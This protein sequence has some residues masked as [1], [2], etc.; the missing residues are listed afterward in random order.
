MF[1]TFLYQRQK[2]ILVQ[3]WGMSNQ[4]LRDPSEMQASLREFKITL[5]KGGCLVVTGKFLLCLLFLA[6]SLDLS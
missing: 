2:R 1:V 3:E 4:F 5:K 6:F